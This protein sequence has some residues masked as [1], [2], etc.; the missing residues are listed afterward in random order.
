ME[1]G[2]THVFLL[3]AADGRTETERTFA[4]GRSCS[5]YALLHRF[6][7]TTN[8]HALAGSAQYGFLGSTTP[9]TA[10]AAAIC[11]FPHAEDFCEHKKPFTIQF[12]DG[13]D[14]VVH[15]GFLYSVL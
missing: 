9:S 7:S 14:G 15:F 3:T 1:K 4:V 2:K 13:G 10:T 12:N 8:T 11:R 5:F 6:D